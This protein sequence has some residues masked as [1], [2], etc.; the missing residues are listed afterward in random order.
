[1]AAHSVLQYL[2]PSLAMQVQGGCSHFLLFAAINPPYLSLIDA[3]GVAEIE[4]LFAK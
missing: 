4:F 1:M 2:L 3:N